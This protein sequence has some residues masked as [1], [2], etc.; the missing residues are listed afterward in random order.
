MTRAKKENYKRKP[1]IKYSLNY[2]KEV[3]MGILAVMSLA[4]VGYEHFL[5][6]ALRVVDD[7]ANLDIIIALIFLSDYFWLLYK[8]ENK[9]KFIFGEWYLLLASIPIV[10]SW[11]E[12]LKAL[13]LF[14]L[15]RLVRAEEH[16][17]FSWKQYKQDHK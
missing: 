15:F 3:I 16:I 7:I 13:R 14:K 5:H 2:Y 11:A 4:S 9:V 10:D 8:A 6:P 12:G 17:N 1:P